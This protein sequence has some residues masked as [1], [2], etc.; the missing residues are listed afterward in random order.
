M[1][2]PNQVSQ[3]VKK[4]DL[5]TTTLPI[6]RRWEEKGVPEHVRPGLGGATASLKIN[7]TFSALWN[8]YPV[9]L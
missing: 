7:P 6:G 2:K 3:T 1:N 4:L 9:S 8:T 5:P